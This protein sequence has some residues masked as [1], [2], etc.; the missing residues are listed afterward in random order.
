M[1]RCAFLTVPAIA[2]LA[3]C[4]TPGGPPPSLQPR[5]AEGI[6]PRLPVVKPINDRPVDPALAGRL[7]ALISQA[8]SG[9]DAF[10]PAAAQ[11]ERLAAAAGPPQSDSWISAQQALSAAVAA[12]TPTSGALSDI[13]ALGADKLQRQGGLAPND[14]AAIDD[15]G[16]IVGAIDERQ[17]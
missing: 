17:A 8:R 16:R 11:A 6:D 4:S 7:A 9:D 3:A 2:A 12:R 15:A 1:R 5:A 10:G 14:L 13:D